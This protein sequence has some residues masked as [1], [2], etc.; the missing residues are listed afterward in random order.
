MDKKWIT[1]EK[2]LSAAKNLQESLKIHPIFC[3]LLVERG[4]KTYNEAKEFFRPSLDQ[5]HDPF[6]MKDMDKAIERIN[7]ALKRNEHVL[8]YGDYDVDGTTSVA[9]VY[10][11][12]KE[13]FEK[14]DFYIPD[15]YTEGYGVST[16]AI[17]WAADQGI[18]LII[19]LDCGVTNIKEIDYSND[20]NIDFIVCDHHLPSHDLPKA[21]AVLDPKREGCEYPFKE[22]AGCGVGF[23]LVQAFCQDQNIPFESI[24]QYLDLVTISIACDIVPIVGENRILAYHGL[25]LLNSK[26]RPGIDNI[27]DLVGIREVDEETG[28]VTYTKVGIEDVVFKIGPKINAAGR[29]SDAKDAVRMMIAKSDEDARNYATLITEHNTTRQEKDKDISEEAIQMVYASERLQAQ[30]SLVL[31]ND[32]WHKGVIGIVASRVVEEFYKPTI[33]LTLSNGLYTGSARSVKEFDIHAALKSCEDLLEKYGG[34]MY[35][36]GMSIHPDNLQKFIERFEYTVRTTIR[37]DQLTPEINIDSELSLD[38]ITPSFFNLLQQFGPFGPQNEKPVFVAKN[39]E[40]SGRSRIVGDNHLKV[41]LKDK[42]SNRAIDGIAFNQKNYFKP[43]CSSKAFHV[44]YTLNENTWRGKSNI[45]LD[46]KD[47]KFPKN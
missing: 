45:Q 31:Y 1:N 22:L 44:C 8:I 40:D 23:K 47:M 35:A 34:H 20:K 39:V 14:I 38:E 4:I 15:R 43:I 42:S 33:M 3:E 13:H 36:A 9:L 10:T 12:F 25:K 29:I 27:Y 16:Q 30:R 6:L 2:D 28:E 5:L 24:L 32:D 11:F 21:H 41:S 46:V 37:E 18:S 26:P 7:Y 17:D 19:S